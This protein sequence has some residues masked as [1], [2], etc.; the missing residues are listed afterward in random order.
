MKAIMLAALILTGCSSFPDAKDCTR[1][2]NYCVGTEGATKTA[3]VVVDKTDSQYPLTTTQETNY[4]ECRANQSEAKQLFL[5]FQ[6]HAECYEKATG[7]VVDRIT[8]EIL[9]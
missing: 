3:P 8:G 4:Y 1:A 6:T 9:N 5:P 7:K 2:R